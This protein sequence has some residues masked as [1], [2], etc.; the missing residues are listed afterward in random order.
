M[1]RKET[2]LNITFRDINNTLSIGS[3]E[4][5][6]NIH[7]QEGRMRLIAV[8]PFSDTDAAYLYTRGKGEDVAYSESSTSSGTITQFSKSMNYK[9]G[10]TIYYLI[11]NIFSYYPFCLLRRRSYFL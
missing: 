6:M 7:I 10:M 1:N 2:P 8:F 4:T 5:S 9:S 3:A 11:L